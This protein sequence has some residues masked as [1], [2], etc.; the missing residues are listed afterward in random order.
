MLLTLAPLA[1]IDIRSDRG[2]PAPKGSEPTREAPQ[3]TI[4]GTPGWWEKEPL[5]I[6][7]AIMFTA[8]GYS[9]SNNWQQNADPA[10]EAGDVAA[11]HALQTHQTSII[12][13]H[14]TNR[15]CYF[16]SPQFKENRRDYL[17]A[18][19]EKSR[20][21]GFRTIVY[22]NVHAV[23]PEFGADRPDWR[24]VRFDG[25]PLD[26]I[27]G[28]ETSFCVNSPWRDWVRDVCLDLCKYPID[29]IFFDG[30][31][32]FAKCCYC[33]HCRKLYQESLG[34]EM[35]PKEAGRPE[36][37]EL[38]RFQA[39]SLRRFLE[40]SNT[41]IKSVRPDVLLY[42]NAGPREEP[43]YLIGRNNRVLVRS[44]DVLAA[45]GGFVY[46]ELS[47]Q[48][49][50]R[51]GSNAKYYQT[52]AAGKPTS[53]FMS[54]SHGPWISYNLSD[55]ELE[56]SF[57]QA[58]VHGSGIWFSGFHWFPKTSAFP[59]IAA[60]FKFFS[61]HRD[62]YFGTR[63]RARA[64]IIWPADAL[65]FYKNPAESP[66]VRQSREPAG[67]INDEFNGFYDA[68]IKAHTPCDILD[69][70][71]LRRED[72]GRYS[73]LVLPNA[74]C[75]GRE[76]DDRLREYVRGG[77]NLIASFETSLCDE[78]GRRQNDF[79]LADLFGVRLLRS[80]VRP[81]PHF[82]FFRRD[83]WPGVFAGIQPELLPA[84]LVSC[85][86]AAAG[87]K[88]VS[89]FSIKFKGWD[90]SEILPSEFPAVAVNE[91]GKGQAVYLAGPFGEHYWK[92]KQPEIRLLLGNLFRW[93]SPPVVRL[94]NAPETVEVVHRETADGRG[95]IT[96]INYSGGL[97]RPFEAIAPIENITI[98]IKKNVGDGSGER[99]I[100]AKLAAEKTRATALK[101][102]RTLQID[103]EGEWLAVRLPRLEIFESIVFE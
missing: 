47:T 35:P 24:Q 72:L 43:Y 58:P 75:T 101:L 59:K 17:A 29:G 2:S 27:Y 57:V 97:T 71:S 86:I 23:K 77:G 85:E 70:E 64:A 19:L 44:Q 31:C 51:V 48:P 50:W 37:G 38:A 103:S 25:T 4:A 92:Y 36:T 74:A 67:S 100:P 10:V 42:C 80:P 69:E 66:E 88:A 73:L 62:I 98:K 16:K 32:L 14:L 99:T 39:E 102:G 30:P 52:Q 95:V 45:E 18:Y 21:A 56:L 22:F 60:E 65:N 12:T 49:A 83:A 26:D 90:G 78:S 55:A 54:P 1:G 9:V 93:L 8:P 68:L 7:E 5:L 41:A 82:Y 79:G 91:F 6:Y 84:P 94:E 28:I 63:S 34:K 3:S 89:P 13:G 11:A 20:A 33:D 40:H 76:A 87:A 81:Y 53:I 46:G 15:F 61:E 96:L